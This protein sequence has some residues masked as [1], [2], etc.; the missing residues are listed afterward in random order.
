M[1]LILEIEKSHQVMSRRVL[2]ICV[3]RDT[4]MDERILDDRVSL[5]FYS[6]VVR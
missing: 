5:I 4:S 1:K 2:T 3:S 6:Y